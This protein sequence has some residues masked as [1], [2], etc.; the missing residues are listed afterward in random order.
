[1]TNMPLKTLIVDDEKPARERLKA[2][3]STCHDV[4]EVSF[5]AGNG[6]EAEFVIE[7][8]KP[9]LVF[10]DIQMPGK[11]V[12]EVLQDI[13]HKPMVVF[14]TAYDEFAL[15]AFESMSIDYL[16]KPVES[17][18]INRVIQK[19]KKFS[20]KIDYRLFDNYL[21]QLNN[22]NSKFKS[23]SH[24]V[25]DKVVLVKVEDITYFEADKKYVNFYDVKCKEYISSH[26]LK[27]LE[28]K[29][30]NN[31]VRISKSLIVNIDFVKSIEKYFG[32]KYVLLL[33][34]YR[35][36]K[37]ITGKAYHQNLKEKIDL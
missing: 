29:L 3:L 16:L 12:F 6:D 28:E 15:Q 23:I 35:S 30:P 31:F 11:N 10:L 20:P 33:K 4:I 1:M 17:N 34:D 25:G 21:N 5:E 8:N 26:P 13:K 24:K 18:Q 37:L 19:L 36:S 22:Q 32:G 14:C 7:S 9:D 2:L 27:S